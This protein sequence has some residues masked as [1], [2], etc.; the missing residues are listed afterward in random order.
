MTQNRHKISLLTPF[1]LC[2]LLTSAAMINDRDTV[3]LA[4]G[5][6]VSI[7]GGAK[8]CTIPLRPLGEIGDI[9]GNVTPTDRFSEN[10]NS[11]TCSGTIPEK[12]VPLNVLRFSNSFPRY[13]CFVA[14]EG[15]FELK[16]LI[17][18]SNGLATAV[19]QKTTDTDF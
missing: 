2:L 7:A 11:Y 19:C 17:Y 4:Q 18:R 16:E 6:V 14:G 10:K 12:F 3:A 9:P 1:S 8:T 15:R 5:N 13:V